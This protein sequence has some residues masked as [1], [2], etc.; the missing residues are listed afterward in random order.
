MAGS[1]LVIVATETDLQ[2]WIPRAEFRVHSIPWW[3][4]ASVSLQERRLRPAH[5]RIVGS[6][7]NDPFLPLTIVTSGVHGKRLANAVDAMSRRIRA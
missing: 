2:F 5:L 4:I 3:A 6:D 7:P 1:T